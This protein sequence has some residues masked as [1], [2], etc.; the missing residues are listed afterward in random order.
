MEPIRVGVI[1]TGFGAKIHTPLLQ[2]HH[3]YEVV[4][5]C[6]VSGKDRQIIAKETGVE[7]VYD[8]WHDMLANERLNLVIVASIPSLHYEMTIEA[9]SMGINVLCEKPMAMD[10]RETKSILDKQASSGLH[11]FINFEWRFMPARQ[12]VKTL[13]DKK[14]IG[15][16]IHIDYDIS[17]PGFKSLTSGMAGWGGQKKHFGGMLG[18]LGSHMIDS[19]LWWSN[20]TIRNLSGLLDTHI[21]IFED[22]HGNSEKRDADDT[23]FVIGHFTGDST[24]KLQLISAAH[25]A[26]GSIVKIFGLKGTIFLKDDMTVH[27]GLV[28]QQL[29]EVNVPTVT[30]PE[31]M[32]NTQSRYYTAFKPFHDALYNRVKLDRSEPDLPTFQDGHRTQVVLD[33]IR[34]SHSEK[35]TIFIGDYS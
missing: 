8:D 12:K 31:G 32:E 29:E 4:S 20:D 15:D 3:Q 33:A 19:L 22:N 25:H 2:W 35:R 14:A 13:L 5:I 21:P 1:G 11:G 17:F 34:L 10:I 23:F 26:T 6:T 28:N 30:A 18:A 7:Q 16:I 27:L 9:L 24:F